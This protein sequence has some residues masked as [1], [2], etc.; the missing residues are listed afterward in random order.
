M[1]DEERSTTFPKEPERALVLYVLAP[2]PQLYL[3]LQW[4]FQQETGTPTLALPLVAPNAGEATL[5]TTLYPAGSRFQT[6]TGSVRIGSIQLFIKGAPW[7]QVS[8]VFMAAWGE[9]TG[10]LKGRFFD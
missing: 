2:H 5:K 3:T 9:N 4:S 8:K 1:E 6:R 7:A 10:N